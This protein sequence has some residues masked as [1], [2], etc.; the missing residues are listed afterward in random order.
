[1]LKGEESVYKKEGWKYKDPHESTG[2]VM[3]FKYAMDLIKQDK[4]K[5]ASQYL[6]D[7]KAFSFLKSCKSLD[8]TDPTVSAHVSKTVLYVDCNKK[9]FTV[10]A[11]FVRDRWTFTLKHREEAHDHIG[12]HE[13]KEVHR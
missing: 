12:K 5:E 6:A 3:A 13:L 10:R 2:A 9:R 8:V 11:A 7:V 1:M 4:Q